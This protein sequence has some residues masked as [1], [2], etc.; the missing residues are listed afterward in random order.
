MWDVL[1]VVVIAIVLFVLSWAVWPP[2]EAEAPVRNQ[3][4]AGANSD[5]V[6]EPVSARVAR[7]AVERESEIPVDEAANPEWKIQGRVVRTDGTPLSGLTVTVFVQEQPRVIETGQTDAEGCFDIEVPE[8]RAM[9]LLVPEAGFVT[10]ARESVWPGVFQ[11]VVLESKI[12][13]AAGEFELRV[14]VRDP[15]GD[16]VP[17]AF[18]RLTPGAEA[19]SRRRASTTSDATG[20]GGSVTLSGDRIGTK[21][22]W[23]DPPHSGRFSGLCVHRREVQIGP[24]LTTIDVSLEAGGVIQGAVEWL[25]DPMAESVLIS[26]RNADGEVRT[27]RVVDGTFRIE[28]LRAVDYALTTTR[29][30]S[31]IALPR[32]RPGEATVTLSLKHERDPRDVGMHMG[33]IH[34]SIFGPAGLGAKIGEV[35][36]IRDGVV[37]ARARLDVAKGGVEWDATT[38][39]IDAFHLVGLTAGDYVVVAVVGRE[40]VARVGPLTVGERELLTGVELRVSGN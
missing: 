28:G 30:V 1:R 34:G 18:V 12:E 5:E 26:A 21:L 4:S 39:R 8:R 20:P 31:P 3:A 16:A 6:A 17:A 15:A 23:V 37:R 25:S 40:E 22:L 35:R 2:T 27:T 9:K 11:D 10:A 32:V 33:E 36:A 38:S 29:P 14:T 19:A 13:D 24:G 7:E